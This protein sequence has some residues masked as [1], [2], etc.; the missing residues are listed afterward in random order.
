MLKQLLNLVK[1]S[2]AGTP[3]VSP[4]QGCDP[5]VEQRAVLLVGQ[6]IVYTLKRSSKRRTIGLCIDDRGLTLSVPLRASER[7]LHVVLQ[8][9]AKWVLEKLERWA[10]R[11]PTALNYVEGALIPYLGE[12]LTLRLGTS[13]LYRNGAELWLQH[14]VLSR[15]QQLTKWYRQQ[16]LP[17]FTARVT[18][19]AALL[20][21][22]PSA[23]KLSTAKTRWGSCTSTGTIRLNLQLIKL[24]QHLIDYVVV[25]ELAHLREMNHSAAYWR[26]VASV[27]PNYAEFRRELTAL[28]LR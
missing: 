28:G 19:Y 18:F 20:N 10:A 15:E 5:S 9:R 22:S 21:V 27:C 4:Q 17:L 7:C 6:R 14:G 23:I 1:R 24:P 2:S 8:G 26:V 3:G 12:T 11:K 13:R 16:A 25:H